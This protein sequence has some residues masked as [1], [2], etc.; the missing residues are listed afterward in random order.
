MMVV[1]VVVILMERQGCSYDSG[2]GGN[3]GIVVVA[4]LW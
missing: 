4:R 2:V 3:E 1:V